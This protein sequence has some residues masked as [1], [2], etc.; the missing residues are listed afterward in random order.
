M[1]I[2]QNPSPLEVLYEDP[3]EDSISILSTEEV[4]LMVRGTQQ[5]SEDDLE[6]SVANASTSSTSYLLASP[7][8]PTL[9][10]RANKSKLVVAATSPFFS[11]MR[12]AN[13]RARN[14]NGG[15]K[16][17]HVNGVIICSDDPDLQFDLDLDLDLRRDT[18]Q[19][20]GRLEQEIHDF[21]EL[22]AEFSHIIATV[23]NF[24]LH[25]LLV[26]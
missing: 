19:S 12:A 14:S 6:E 22:I 7:N 24:K 23:R 10:G 18:L 17:G 16:I 8:S 3:K 26:V 1:M 2:L 4:G 15:G 11:Q 21:Q 13:S 5:E 25:F 20:W 9:L